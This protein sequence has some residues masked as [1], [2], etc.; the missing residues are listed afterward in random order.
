V[1]GEWDDS[2]V[3]PVYEMGIEYLALF[4]GVA[5]SARNSRPSKSMF[6]W[7]ACWSP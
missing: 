5:P 7:C 1:D 2:I 3:K 4:L 6:A